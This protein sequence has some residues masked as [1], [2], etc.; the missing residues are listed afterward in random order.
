MRSI[1]RSLHLAS[2][3]EK[4]VF[5]ESLSWIPRLGLILNILSSGNS[6]HEESASSTAAKSGSF[7]PI[8]LGKPTISRSLRWLPSRRVVSTFTSFLNVSTVIIVLILKVRSWWHSERS[9]WSRKVMTER[10]KESQQRAMRKMNLT[11]RNHYV[12]SS[13]S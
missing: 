3:S 9:I 1:L 12:N 8:V 11:F 10:S 6:F 2:S 4:R 13:E 7:S 5:H